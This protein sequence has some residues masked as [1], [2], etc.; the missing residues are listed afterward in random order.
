M[1]PSVSSVEAGEQAVI[2]KKLKNCLKRV[3][4]SAHY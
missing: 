3:F 1:V 4:I 2:K